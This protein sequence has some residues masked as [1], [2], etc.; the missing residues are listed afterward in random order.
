MCMCFH[1]C[2]W[3]SSQDCQCAHCGEQ[4]FGHLNGLQPPIM[5]YIIVFSNMTSQN[6]CCEKG[7]LT[8]LW[9]C[10][11]EFPLYHSD[12]KVKSYSSPVSWGITS[13]LDDSAPH[14]LCPP[15]MLKPN[16][17]ILCPLCSEIA[18]EV[19]EVRI[20]ESSHLWNIFFSNLNHTQ[21]VV[22]Q[23]IP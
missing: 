11:G 6:V 3:S 18:T 12:L 13:I 7:L 23:T 15:P 1:L 4:T 14:D 5:S 20:V 22:C 9:V 16:A 19:L 21:N 8:A 10:G 17:G 2:E